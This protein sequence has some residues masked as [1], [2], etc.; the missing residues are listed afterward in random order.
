LRAG[1]AALFMFL[2]AVAQHGI[3]GS[4]EVNPIRIDLAPQARSAALVC[5]RAQNGALGRVTNSRYETPQ[6]GSSLIIVNSL[7]RPETAT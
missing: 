5:R 7:C 6:P 2:C 3:S 1:R 4:F